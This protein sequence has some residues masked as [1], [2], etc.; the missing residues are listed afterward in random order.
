MM[1]L[2]APLSPT[3]ATTLAGIG[4]ERNV[5]DSDQLRL[6]RPDAHAEPA[7]IQYRGPRLFKLPG[8]DQKPIDFFRS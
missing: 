4:P 3:S 6:A 1:L 5:C 2:P 7:Y 8:I